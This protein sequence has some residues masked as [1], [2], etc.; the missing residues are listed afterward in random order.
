MPDLK[1][2]EVVRTGKALTADKA[3]ELVTKWGAYAIHMGSKVTR[4]FAAKVGIYTGVDTPYSVMAALDAAKF[5]FYYGDV[6]D[7]GR[8]VLQYSKSMFGPE[9][10]RLVMSR[11]EPLMRIWYVDKT[12]FPTIRDIRVTGWSMQ[13]AGCIEGKCALRNDVRTF[14][15]QRIVRWELI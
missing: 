3:V 8:G 12:M 15:R 14:S 1:E 2:A 5:S 10:D 11:T 9:F 4:V 7:A 13:Y 6:V